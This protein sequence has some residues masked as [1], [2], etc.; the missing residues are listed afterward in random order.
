MLKIIIAILIGFL[1][2]PPFVFAGGNYTQL[3]LPDFRI[4]FTPSCGVNPDV[5]FV[6]LGDGIFE[7]RNSVANGWV[8]ESVVFGEAVV[9]ANSES[10]FADGQSWFCVSGKN[11]SAHANTGEKITL[12]DDA[13]LKAVAYVG[14]GGGGETLSTIV[15]D[16]CSADNTGDW[17]PFDS[18]LT[19]DTDHYIIT[20]TAD[21]QGFQQNAGTVTG[22]LY[23][24]E[25]KAING[26][27]GNVVFK[28]RL[29]PDESF[30]FI[31]T[32][33]S[34]QSLS[35]YQVQPSAGG[36]DFSTYVYM[37]VNG[38]TIFVKDTLLQEVTDCDPSG[39]HVTKTPTGS[40]GWKYDA[41]FNF[42][43]IEYVLFTEDDPDGNLLGWYN[44]DQYRHEF[45]G[46]YWAGLGEPEG[47]N[48]CLWN[49]KLDEAGSWTEQGTPVHT[50]NEIGIDGVNNIAHTVGDNSVA[51]VEGV[52]QPVTI[53]DDNETH[54]FSFF[55]KKDTEETTFPM[56][57]LLLSG[58][59]GITTIS[60]INTKTGARSVEM[61]TGCDSYGNWWRFWI[62]ATNDSSGNVTAY[63]YLFPA[64]TT[65][66]AN[67]ATVVDAVRSMIYD[68]GQFELNKKFPSSPIYTEGSAVTRATEGG[69]YPRWNLPKDVLGTGNMFAEALGGELITVQ[70][71]RDFSAA[72][73]WTNGDINA[74]DET[75]DLTVTANA[76]G[77][78]C[79]LPDAQAVMASG[80][81]YK[82]EFDVANLV[83]NWTIKDE[84]GS[85][86]ISSTVTD[87][88]TNSFTF[89]YTG[90]AGGGIRLTSTAIDSSGDFDNFTLKE[91]TNSW[92][93]MGPHF[94]MS[95]W[96]RPGFD[97]GD[98][99]TGDYGLFSTDGNAQSGLYLNE[100]GELCVFDG[101]TEAKVDVN[102]A[103]DTWYRGFWQ[104]GYLVDNVA[105]MRVGFATATGNTITWGTAV[106]YDGTYPVGANFETCVGL[107]GPVHSQ[108]AEGWR[109]ILSDSE[110]L[111]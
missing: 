25:A 89:E 70:G 45:V 102:G 1:A 19:F 17:T 27:S 98:V 18:T 60:N 78:Y 108:Q 26:T 77:Q 28:L 94:S 15:D 88:T 67:T 21:S 95:F 61:D 38:H 47:V 23:K 99:A 110:L 16:D 49:R 109:R 90:T 72:T 65:V 35:G 30:D 96:F 41:N 14:A 111:N 5:D 42:N 85:Y 7:G 59:S 57:K 37:T 12:V 66:W 4:P 24:G 68:W 79:T 51:A 55:I 11:Y 69:G 22:K 34:W 100:N 48:E 87:A 71:D 73:S 54:V 82:L 52:Y 43:A 92:N 50:K 93:G 39:L 101:T 8:Q 91:T 63:L 13:G 44:N 83:S 36:N 6:G 58:G 3:V 2:L 103:K 29:N 53:A 84:T 104:A 74:Y 81:V 56:L 10:S 31:T 105:K 86:V 9:S 80:K 97:H 46:G 20:R 107:T 62:R 106:A 40:E 33:G 75:N 64:N 76:I 32:S